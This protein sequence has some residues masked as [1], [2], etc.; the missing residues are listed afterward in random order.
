MIELPPSAQKALDDILGKIKETVVS[1]M[2][3][4][5]EPEYRVMADG[6]GFGLVP[7]NQETANAIIAQQ[8][9]LHVLYKSAMNV[10]YQHQP[11]D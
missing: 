5:H 9:A 8:K 2:P 11:Q 1:A 6:Q 3:K 4:D 7:A 10:M